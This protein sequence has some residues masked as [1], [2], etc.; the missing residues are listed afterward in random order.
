MQTFLK[1]ETVRSY[2]TEV[3]VQLSAANETAVSWRGWARCVRTD[4]RG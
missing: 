4:G 3:S 1:I 2:D